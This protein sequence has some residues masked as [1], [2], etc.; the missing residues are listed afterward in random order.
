M[1]II[2]VNL[3]LFLLKEKDYARVNRK[4]SDIGVTVLSSYLFTLGA[5]PY[6]IGA[7]IIA[8]NTRPGQFNLRPNKFRLPKVCAKTGS[9]NFGSF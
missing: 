1:R 9:C 4:K 6:A 5:N 2:A 8:G 7:T 3:C